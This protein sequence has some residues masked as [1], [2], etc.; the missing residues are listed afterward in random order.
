MLRLII[1]DARILFGQKCFVQYIST[2]ICIANLHK[3]TIKAF[4]QVH[5]MS[6]DLF[7]PLTKCTKWQKMVMKILS[8]IATVE[9]S[10]F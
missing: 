1:F 3:S 9:I 10:F 5:K 2:L 7:K 6:T 8:S 4:R